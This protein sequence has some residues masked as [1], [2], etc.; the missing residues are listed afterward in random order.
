MEEYNQL[1]GDPLSPEKENK[2]PSPEKKNKGFGHGLMVGILVSLFV[3]L[4]CICVTAVVIVRAYPQ[5]TSFQNTFPGYIPDNSEGVDLKELNSKLSTIQTY[6]SSFYLWDQDPEEAQDAAI[7]GFVQS[8]GDKYSEYYN[9]EE[10][11]RLN[12]SLT[13]TYSGIGALVSQNLDTGE[14]KVIYVYPGTPAEESGVQEGD[15]IYKVGD[16]PVDGIELD[17]LVSVYIQGE[18]GTQVVITFLRGEEREEVVIPITRRSVK[19]PYVESE[20]KEDHI[21]Y[22]RITQFTETAVEEFT[23]AVDDLIGKGAE[24][25]IIDLRDNPGG[26]LEACV[27][28]CAYILPQGMVTYTAGK[29]GS[30]KRYNTVDD[31]EV[32]LPLVILVNGNSASASEVMTGAFM[33]HN[34]AI[35][36]GTRTFGKGIVQGVF[37]LGDGSA[38]KL[39]TEH[40]YTPNGF[41]LH[42]EGLVP[43]IEI[44]LSDACEEYCDDNDNQYRKAVEILKER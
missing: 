9:P 11:A 13:G 42:G 14:T 5:V 40:Y 3:F 1:N 24:S 20:L 36:I 21:G 37:P 7:K 34:K 41:D 4:I 38:L 15:I 43:D 23:N 31:H 16:V 12:V 25:L 28:I 33:D 35:V 10:Y 22:I 6:I 29:D 27:R 19:L 26:A 8:L 30:G 44:N 39:T 18:E 32:D 17:E 2:A